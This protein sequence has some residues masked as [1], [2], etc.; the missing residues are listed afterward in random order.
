MALQIE[1]QAY[2]VNV[3]A[4]HTVFTPY[5]FVQKIACFEKNNTWQVRQ[6]YHLDVIQYVLLLPT[7]KLHR[8]TADA[9]VMSMSAALCLNHM[10]RSKI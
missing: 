5:G 2:P 10:Y 8:G 6:V 9:D 4:L 3:E 1:N 7:A